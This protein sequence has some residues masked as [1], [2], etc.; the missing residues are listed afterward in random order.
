MYQNDME[1]IKFNDTYML[2]VFTS[3]KFP[4]Q[5]SSSWNHLE[6]SLPNDLK[7][8]FNITRSKVPHIYVTSVPE[9]KNVAPFCS[10]INHFRVLLHDK[11]TI[12]RQINLN[13]TRSKVPHTGSVSAPGFQ[14]LFRFCSTGTSFRLTVHL[15]FSYVGANGNLCTSGNPRKIKYQKTYSQ[16]FEDL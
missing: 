3:F 11:N 15:D 9:S 8:T 13:A 6:S 1:Y 5:S 2:L 14:F 10:T 4:F 12:W 16:T 7:I